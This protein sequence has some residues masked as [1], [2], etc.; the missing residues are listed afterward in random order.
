MHRVGLIEKMGTGI[1]RIQL[2]MNEAGLLPVE[3]KFT[4]FVNATFYKSNYIDNN[5]K[6]RR[7]VRRKY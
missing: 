6:V 2:L 5:K 1:S 3:Y 7:K 4:D